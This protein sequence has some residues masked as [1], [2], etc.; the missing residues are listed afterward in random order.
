MDSGIA[1]H[2]HVYSPLKALQCDQV[3][4]ICGNDLAVQYIAHKPDNK[5]V[6]KD[7]SSIRL[8][9]MLVCV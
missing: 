9:T 8:Q 3:L 1:Q 6:H 2:L 5:Q 4:Y 7:A